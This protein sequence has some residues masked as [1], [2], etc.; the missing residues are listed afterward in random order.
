MEIPRL[1][2]ELKPQL[3]AYTTVHGNARSLTEWG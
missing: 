3:L 1:G 2:A